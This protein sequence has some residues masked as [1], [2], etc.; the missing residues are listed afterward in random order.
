[1]GR[2]SAP[3]VAGVAGVLG[4]AP[5]VV[6]AGAA[7]APTARAAGEAVAGGAAGAGSAADPGAANRTPTGSGVRAVA[8]CHPHLTSCR[9][10]S[11]ASAAREARTGRAKATGNYCGCVIRG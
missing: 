5:V 2:A 11:S 9:R 3:V 8:S 6:A 7:A 1:L 10:E 4:V